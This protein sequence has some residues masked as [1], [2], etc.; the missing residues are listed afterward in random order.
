MTSPA[1]RTRKA[2]HHFDSIS[3][4]SDFPRRFSAPSPPKAMPRPTP[5]QP[6][7]IPPSSAAATSAASPRPAPARPPRSPCRSF[8]A[9]SAARQRPAA[10]PAAP[11]CSARPVS[12][13]ARSPTAFAPTAP[14]CRCRRRW[15]SAASRSAAQRQQLA[16]GV[17]ILVAT[18][19]RL[20]DLID[21]RVAEPGERPGSGARRGRPHA[22]PGLHPC[23]QAHRQA[24]AA[25][26]GKPCCFRR[27]CR[28]RSPP[29]PRTIC[30]PGQGSRH[31]GRHHGRADR[32]GGRIRR[33]R[34]E[35]RPARDAAAR[36][37]LRPRAGVHADQARRRPRRAA[38]GRGRHPGRRHPRQQVAAAARARPRRLSRRPTR[39]CSS[40]PTSPPAGS[41]STAS[42]M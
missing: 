6:Q 39:A 37:G 18:P 29:S 33:G 20:L 32:P 23:P 25:A 26:S 34:P 31:P 22:R 35:A 8:S 40:P 4:T 14:A 3:P 27:R 11:S 19:G 36:P 17:D 1:I 10:Q 38:S 41:T 5:I 21:S 12:W 2:V 9:L 30:G 13:R 28:R 15:C 24:A 7:A 16:R 42:R